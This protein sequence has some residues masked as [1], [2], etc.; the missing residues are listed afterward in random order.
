MPFQCRERERESEAFVDDATRS[1]GDTCRAL[2]NEILQIL[3]RTLLSSS[4]LILD[5]IEISL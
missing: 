5:W 3:S 2:E 4:P 1:L